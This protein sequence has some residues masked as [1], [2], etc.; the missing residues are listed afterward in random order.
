MIGR[1]V[2]K[3]NSKFL[4]AEAMF[5][6]AKVGRIQQY[7]NENLGMYIKRLCESALECCNPVNEE[8]L[9]DVCF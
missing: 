6:L 2:S 1:R 9:V 7:S 3:F 5:T 8:M 4:Y